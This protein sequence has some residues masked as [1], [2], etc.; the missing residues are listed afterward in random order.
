MNND[1]T[2]FRNNLKIFTVK[3]NIFKNS[4]FQE[5]NRKRVIVLSSLGCKIK[6]ANPEHNEIP[7][8]TLQVLFL[9]KIESITEV[10]FVR[11]IRGKVR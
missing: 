11:K 1:L 5:W 3:K 6:D 7:I 2:K 8:V 4:Q 9:E 10:V